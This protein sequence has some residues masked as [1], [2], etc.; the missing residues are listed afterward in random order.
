MLHRDLTVG[1]IH[2]IYNWVVADVAAL[3]DLEVGTLDHGKVAYVEEGKLLFFLS[4]TVDKLW[5]PLAVTEV[6]AVVIG[7]PAGGTIGQILAKVSNTD[8]DVEWIDAPTGGGTPPDEDDDMAESIGTWTPRLVSMEDSGLV[9]F[10][11]GAAV[12]TYHRL[13]NRVFFDFTVNGEVPAGVLTGNLGLDGFPFPRVINDQQTTVYFDSVGIMQT[14]VYCP[15]VTGCIVNKYVVDD[16]TTE[17]LMVFSWS[18]DSGP[19]GGVVTAAIT[20]VTSVS[21]FCSGSYLAVA[22]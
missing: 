18:N 11:M 15:L 17:A 1:D 5:S 12:G 2:A 16:P 22:V 7:I 19:Q 6:G 13:G 4:N 9:G 14:D 10:D 3:E 21:M 8:Y 20:D